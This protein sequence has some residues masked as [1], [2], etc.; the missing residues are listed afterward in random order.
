MLSVKVKNGF[1]NDFYITKSKQ[2]WSKILFTGK[3]WFNL[4]NQYF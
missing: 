4:L 3:F 1:S 2:L